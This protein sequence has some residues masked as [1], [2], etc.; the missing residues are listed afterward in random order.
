M[1]WLKLEEKLDELPDLTPSMEQL[2]T[3]HY[4][5]TREAD[6]FS[7]LCVESTLVGDTE[8]AT[9]WAR[10]AQANEELA[11]ELRQQKR[12]L[13][14]GRRRHLAPVEVTKLYA[15]EID[16]VE[17]RGA[18]PLLEDVVDVRHPSG[19]GERSAVVG[20][21][22]GRA[23][24]NEA[25]VS[26][27]CAPEAAL[28]DAVHEGAHSAGVG[29]E[30]TGAGDV[31]AEHL[32][33]RDEA[34]GEARHGESPSPCVVEDLTAA[35]GGSSGGGPRD[36]RPAPTVGPASDARTPLAAATPPA[37]AAEGTAASHPAGG[38]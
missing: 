32:A 7:R 9:H 29:V 34:D 22:S 38:G 11:D 23:G 37:V 1:P 20:D 26:V 35:H 19:H 33:G 13:H 2:N 28:V 4:R 25:K 15:T 10:R 36:S 8:K 16:D 12:D 3:L 24:G 14:R 27:D 17:I 30:V 21:D 18:R 31:E 6:M 5:A